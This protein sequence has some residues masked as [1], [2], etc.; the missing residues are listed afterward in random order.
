MDEAPLASA[1][2]PAQPTHPLPRLTLPSQ[3]RSRRRPL[4]I[5]VLQQASQNLAG[6]GFRDGVGKD[7][8]AGDALVGGDAGFHE[9]VDGGGGDV[10][11]GGDDVG[12]GVFFTVPGR[13]VGVS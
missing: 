3:L 4:A 13:R 1:T 5:L 2:S 8:A 12:L 6:R 10:L 9:G 11:A 7:N